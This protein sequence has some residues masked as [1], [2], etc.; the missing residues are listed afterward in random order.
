MAEG[1]KSSIESCNLLLYY[2]IIVI[3]LGFYL[4]A[5]QGT[6]EEHSE[7]WLCQEMD[8]LNHKDHR[9]CPS[10]FLALL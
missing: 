4:C 10:A 9:I 5:A 2:C 1:S 6:E 3:L 7:L 8:F